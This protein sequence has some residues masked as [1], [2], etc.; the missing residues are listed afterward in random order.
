MVNSSPK[1]AQFHSNLPSMAS[2]PKKLSSPGTEW[3]NSNSIYLK[4]T[5]KRVSQFPLVLTKVKLLDPQNTFQM[6]LHFRQ[7]S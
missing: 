4:N 2:N 7:A 6:Y 1:V 5:Q 3:V